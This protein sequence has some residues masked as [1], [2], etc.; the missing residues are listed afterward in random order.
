MGITP[1]I[2]G[3]DNSKKPIRY[4][5]KLYKERNKIWASFWQNEGLAHSGTLRG[6]G[7]SSKPIGKRKYTRRKEIAQETVTITLPCHI[8]VIAN[9]FQAYYNLYMSF[10]FGIL[11]SWMKFPRPFSNSGW[12]VF[13]SSSKRSQPISSALQ[14]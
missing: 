2:S 11:Y 6:L 3:R 1:C 10:D 4:N 12:E 7:T 9:R 13:Y 14:S 8:F 5:K